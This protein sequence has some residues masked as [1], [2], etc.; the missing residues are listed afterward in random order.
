MNHDYLIHYVSS[1]LHTNIRLYTRLQPNTLQTEVLYPGLKSDTLWLKQILNTVPYTDI[2]QD[3]PA[4]ICLDAEDPAC[5]YCRIFSANHVYLI[6]PCFPKDRMEYLYNLSRLTVKKKN[7]GT[8]SRRNPVP[9]PKNQYAKYLARLIHSAALNQEPFASTYH[10][11][12]RQVPG[13]PEYSFSRTD[14][15]GTG[16]PADIAASSETTGNPAAQAG[17]NTS[18]TPAARAGQKKAGASAVQAGQNASG[19]LNTTGVPDSIAD[20][21]EIFHSDSFLC[22]LTDL[23]EC[24]L[25]LYYW[26]GSAPISPEST[27]LTPAQLLAANSTQ[28]VHTTQMLEKYNEILLNNMEH[29]IIHNPYNQEIREYSAVENGDV[30]E[31][32]RI[33]K[34][35]YTA[36]NGVLSP[37]PLR[38]EIN[39]G[40]VI[41][42]LSRSAAARGGVSPE[43]C[44]SLSD[45]AIQ[46]ME[47]CRDVSAVRH[48]ARSAQLRYTMLAHSAQE[49]RV[50]Q[51]PAA[52][53]S[54]N[55]H[56]NHCKDYIF[57]HLNRKLTVRQIADAIGLETNYLSTLFHKCENI[58]LKQYIIK[59]KINL[60]KNMLAYSPYSY[61]EIANYLGFSSQSHMGEQFRRITGLTMRQYRERYS[62]EDFLQDVVASE[63]QN[64]AG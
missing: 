35:D 16:I 11:N 59:E 45:A 53:D 2:P 25:L 46:E 22:S 51:R 64:P 49:S 56:I 19:F 62:K 13:I 61:I 63:S 33:Q 18:G 6:G 42:T 17:Q 26:N 36:R 4:L 41:I 24:A 37:D 31:V 52:S 29:G 44:Y 30:E 28:S 9:A 7:T 32:K 14:S 27:Y 40:I 34:E 15:F 38:N 20:S 10:K 1:H 48:I 12:E 50:G 3:P 57:T 8:A 23:A 54:N 5:I 60:A 39:M 43:A 47:S 55:R 58:T 21:D